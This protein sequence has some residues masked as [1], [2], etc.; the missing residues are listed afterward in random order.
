MKKITITLLT[1]LVLG[2]CSQEP[3]EL[4]RCIEANTEEANY[5]QRYRESWNSAA[6]K[7][8]EEEKKD[9][10]ESQ[11]VPDW[12]WD[13]E[14]IPK[15]DLEE[16][17]RNCMYEKFDWE[18]FATNFA[19]SKNKTVKELEVSIWL[20][21]PLRNEYLDE[22]FK[23]VDKTCGHIIESHSEDVLKLCHS[24]GIY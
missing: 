17:M 8:T 20:D 7:F 19:K 10:V 23:E 12:V 14:P 3:T 2:G 11:E 5:L 16:K 9:F 15:N 18:A 24:Q 22:W 21:K 4:E 6:D 13:E 1:L